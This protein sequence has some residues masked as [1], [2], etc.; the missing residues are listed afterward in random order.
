MIIN[1]NQNKFSRY[2]IDQ[3]YI[4]IDLKIKESRQLF[5]SR[6]PAPFR[7]RDLDDEAVE[8]ITVAA[9]EFKYKTPL[10]IR[11]YISEVIDPSLSKEMINQALRGYFEYESELLSMKLNR[12]FK[13]GQVFLL[14]GVIW[15]VLCLALARFFEKDSLMTHSTLNDAIIQGVTIVGWVAMWRPLEIFLFDW[16]PIWQ[17]KRLLEKL[18]TS[19][20]EIYEGSVSS[21]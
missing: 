7:E 5:D 15:L 19:P 1:K 12:F 9:D 11:I 8:Y 6:D 20:I 3:G 21:E 4:C 18:S 13:T 2:K 14:I 10:K 16:I 17:K